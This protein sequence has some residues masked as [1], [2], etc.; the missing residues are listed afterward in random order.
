MDNSSAYIAGIIDGEGTITLS[1]FS[2]TAKYR[3]LVV[4]VSSTTI[5]I[6]EFLQSKYGGSISKQKVYKKHHKQ[7]WSWKLES[8][9]ALGLLCDVLPFLLEPEK[10]RRARLALSRYLEV[11]PRNGKYTEEMSEAKLA[12]EAEFFHPSTA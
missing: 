5:Q 3:Y 7:S 2:K 11:T 9:R 8:R 4:S 1:R 10:A 12:F 6:L